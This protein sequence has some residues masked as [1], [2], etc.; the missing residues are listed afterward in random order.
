M[1]F[2]GLSKNPSKQPLFDILREMEGKSRKD[3]VETSRI[4]TLDQYLKYT[5]VI[6]N[7]VE[8]FWRKNFL[9]KGAQL[10]IMSISLHRHAAEI[11]QNFFLVPW[12]EVCIPLH[13]RVI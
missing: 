1:N 11:F 6:Q 3:F 10:K 13:F 4:E 5:K 8:P 9:L 2:S 12:I 7:F